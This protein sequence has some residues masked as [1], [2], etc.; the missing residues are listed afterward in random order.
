MYL[1]ILLLLS[2]LLTNSAVSGLIG[3]LFHVQG[4][5][6]SATTLLFNLSWYNLTYTEYNALNSINITLTSSANVVLS[7]GFKPIVYYDVKD[8][9]KLVFYGWVLTL[10]AKSVNYNYTPCYFFPNDSIKNLF[11]SSFLR[12]SYKVFVGPQILNITIISQPNKYWLIYLNKTLIGF[13]NMASTYATV[14]GVLLSLKSENINIPKLQFNEFK[15][16]LENGSWVYLPKSDDAL[17]LPIN[18]NSSIGVYYNGFEGKLIIG[19]GIKSEA[20]G[21][22]ITAITSNTPLLT[23]TV[24]WLIITIIIVIGVIILIILIW[25][26]RR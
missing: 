11:T 13:V 24:I 7:L 2:I 23:S 17:L 19:S 16:R 15:I 18:K 22:T 8:Y 9:S 12:G 20:I 26:R 25:R 10:W 1:K 14:V 21:Y 4:L 3:Y 5:Q 6:F